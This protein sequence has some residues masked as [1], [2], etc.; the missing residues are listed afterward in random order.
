MRTQL[1]TPRGPWTNMAKVTLDLPWTYP[2]ATLESSCGGGRKGLVSDPAAGCRSRDYPAIRH[3]PLPWPSQLRDN[4][5]RRCTGMQR[6][7]LEPPRR[8]LH[9]GI[10]LDQVHALGR[11]ILGLTRKLTL[12]PIQ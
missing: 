2:G 6:I 9:A 3:R 10:G 4:S 8:A 1:S 7:P 11:E 12:K 5:H